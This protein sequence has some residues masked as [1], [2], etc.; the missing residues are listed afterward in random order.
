MQRFYRVAPQ[1]I[2]PAKNI[3]QLVSQWQPLIPNLLIV[4]L[5]AQQVADL[6]TSLSMQ[7][8]RSSERR[9]VAALSAL[10]PSYWPA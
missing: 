2:T 1:Q 7:I 8:G 6:V 3:E 10:C 9:E 4:D 5:T